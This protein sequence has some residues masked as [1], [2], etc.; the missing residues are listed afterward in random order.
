METAKI[1]DIDT[2]VMLPEDGIINTEWAIS[3]LSRVDLFSAS[4][5]NYGRGQVFKMLQ[6]SLSPNGFNQ[7]ITD[8]GYTV[9]TAL[10]YISY[11]EKKPVLTAIK[12]KYYVAL[13]LSA[14]EYIPDNL[15]DAMALLDIC[16]ARF[17]KPTADNL[18]K[19]AEASGT[20]PQKMS[21]SA[22]SVEAA[23][24]KALHDWLMDE[25]Q[26]SEDD[27]HQASTIDNTGKT[28]FLEKMLEAYSLLVDWDS[29]YKLIA[30]TIAENGTS[31]QI[32]FLSDINDASGSIAEFLESEKQYY[33]LQALV[34]TF[35]NSIYPKQQLAKDAS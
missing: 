15:E 30:P 16:L 23:K 32:R 9:E 25:Y 21:D 17:G 12:D 28:E 22:I 5:L 24:K 8:L 35:E 14:A 13:S 20:L 34:E 26:I 31:E 18:R 4:T 7:T 3:Q 29:M 27:I 1:E 19:S 11:L 33:S 10:V 6:T 2:G